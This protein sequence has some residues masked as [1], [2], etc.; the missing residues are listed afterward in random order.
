[1]ADS[2]AA[3]DLPGPP[4]QGPGDRHPPS[5]DTGLPRQHAATPAGKPRARALGI[6][7][8]GT[9]GRWNAITDVPGVE[10]GYTTL[11]HGESVRTGVT[12]I[13]PRGQTG[14]AIRWRP[15][16]SPRMATGR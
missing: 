10:V 8:G 9:P 13:H 12:A 6:P 15:G 1:M 16:S 2:M 14:P 5:D 7:L 4:V 3:G 11:I